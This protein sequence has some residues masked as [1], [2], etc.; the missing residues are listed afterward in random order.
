MGYLITG[1]QPAT[2]ILRRLNV[3]FTSYSNLI[4]ISIGCTDLPI[5]QC[6]V[7][8]F[9]YNLVLLESKDSSI[10][11]HKQKVCPQLS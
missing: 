5:T 2:E 11:Q 8:R 10:E 6:L 3:L 9:S 7:N 4:D 1:Y